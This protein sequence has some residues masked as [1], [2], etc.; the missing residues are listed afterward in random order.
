MLALHAEASAALE[1]LAKFFKPEMKLTF[2][3]RHPTAV[4]RHVIV[5]ND[6]VTGL[7]QLLAAE[8]EREHGKQ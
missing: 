2:I 5:T 6:D 1:S 4:E 3:A 8:A 7:A